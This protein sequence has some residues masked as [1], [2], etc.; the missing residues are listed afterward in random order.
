MGGV[1]LKCKCGSFK[2][3][4]WVNFYA[5]SEGYPFYDRILIEYNEYIIKRSQAADYLKVSRQT[6]SNWEN[7]KTYLDIFNLVL[8][9]EFYEVS[10]DYL[11]KEE[12]KCQIIWTIIRI[13]LML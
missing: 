12:K 6:I 13:V 2:M 11:L 7:E 4:R 1:S 5:W 9:S 10:L 3:I 8:I